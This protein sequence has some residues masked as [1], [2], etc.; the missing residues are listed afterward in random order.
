MSDP[1]APDPAVE[2]TPPCA[3]EFLSLFRRVEAWIDG[4]LLLAEEGGALL[5]EI[6]AAG[7]ARDAG[8]P[9]AVRRHTERFLR[10]L[11]ALIASGELDAEDGHPALE[12]A[13]EMLNTERDL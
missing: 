10:A 9:V 11:E 12:A 2:V 8:D 3:A 4:D 7:R 1:M 6:A 13:R 5:A